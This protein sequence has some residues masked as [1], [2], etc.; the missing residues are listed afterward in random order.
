MAESH[1]NGAKFFSRHSEGLSLCLSNRGVLFVY[2]CRL[3]KTNASV[4]TL[5]AVREGEHFALRVESVTG[6]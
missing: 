5:A 4:V 2:L 3:G 6:P 1:L